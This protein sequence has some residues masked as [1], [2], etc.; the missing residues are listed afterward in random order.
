MLAPDQLITIAFIAIFLIIVVLY[1]NKLKND[2]K[3]AEEEELANQSKDLEMNEVFYL[4]KHDSEKEWL[5]WILKQKDATKEKAASM[6]KL[7]LNGPINE[8]CY[9]TIHA[10]NCIK[11]FKGFSLDEFAANLFERCSQNWNKIKNVQNYYYKAAEILIDANPDLAVKT[12]ETEITTKDYSQGAMERRRSIIGKLPELNHKSVNL[13][14]DIL[15]NINESY[16]TKVFALRKC[17]DYDPEIK[18]TIYLETLRRIIE[19]YKNSRAVAVRI[20]GTGRGR[21]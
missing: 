5:D 7:H 2:R 3:R 6:L 10:L 13:M 18:N 8:W 11:E 9:M 19:K 4:Y 20:I 14:I 17:E 21:H 1:N 15:S 16:G 12:F